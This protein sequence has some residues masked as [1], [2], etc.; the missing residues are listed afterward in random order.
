MSFLLGLTLGFLIGALCVL[1]F[2]ERIAEF[3]ADIAS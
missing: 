3:L 2:S 1:L